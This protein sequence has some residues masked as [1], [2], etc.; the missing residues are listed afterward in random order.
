MK[1]IKTQLYPLGMLALLLGLSACSSL[2]TA[3]ER[4]P[5]VAALGALEEVQ[6][7]YQAGRYGEVILYVARSDDLDQAPASV[8]IPAL[9]L[10]AFSYCVSNYLQ[11][12]E[13]AFAR[14]LAIDPGFEL[15]PAEIGHPI[16]GPAYQ[17]A[18]QAI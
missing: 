5:T 1:R 16:W 17:R 8:K 15:K 14:I 7:A 9:K 18:K 11:L 12:C 2:R 3:T 13:D 6:T 10:Q 4:P